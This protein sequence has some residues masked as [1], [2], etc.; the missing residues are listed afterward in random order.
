MNYE[1]TLHQEDE[2][3]PPE[4]KLIKNEPRYTMTKTSWS[5]LL[6]FISLP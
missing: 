4:Q 3:A 1:E 5:L 6:L 2:E